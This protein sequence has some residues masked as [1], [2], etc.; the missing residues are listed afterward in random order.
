LANRE[1]N[2]GVFGDNHLHD[3]DQGMQA[4][5]DK[6]DCHSVGIATLKGRMQTEFGD[7]NAR[8]DDLT[9]ILEALGLCANMNRGRR[10]ACAVDEARDQP[11][12]ELIRANPLGQYDLVF[13]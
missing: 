12:L 10:E 4:T 2:R 13:I 9:T 7:I 11:V 3:G 8:F 6:L 1:E 5:W